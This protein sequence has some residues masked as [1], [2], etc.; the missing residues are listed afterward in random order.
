MVVDNS[1]ATTKVFNVACQGFGN[2]DI[3]FGNY[4]G[5]ILYFVICFF[6]FYGLLVAISKVGVKK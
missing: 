2:C 1:V 4:L 6:A 3:C 5:L